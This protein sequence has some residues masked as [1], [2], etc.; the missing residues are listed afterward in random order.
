MVI[1]KLYEIPTTYEDYW[2][3]TCFAG[4]IH[5]YLWCIGHTTFTE[6]FWSGTVF[7]KEEKDNNSFILLKMFDGCLQVVYMILRRTN[8]S[9]RHP[10]ISYL[11][12]ITFF[13]LIKQKAQI[14]DAA[15]E[16][17]LMK[18]EIDRRH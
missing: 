7:P 16:T 6:C 1:F 13:L 18:H 11:K 4:L 10:W 5:D 12:K 14:N 2:I 3:L 8:S 17:K 15:I 9:S